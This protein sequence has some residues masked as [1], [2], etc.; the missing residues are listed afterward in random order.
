MSPSTLEDKVAASDR[1]TRDPPLPHAHTSRKKLHPLIDRHKKTRDH[2]GVHHRV[3]RRP[4]YA[5]DAFSA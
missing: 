2:R 1:S 4:L 5:Y 3:H